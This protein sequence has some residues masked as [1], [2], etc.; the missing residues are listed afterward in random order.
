[1]IH[2]DHMVRA[3]DDIIVPTSLS[4]T[5]TTESLTGTNNL[6]LDR[7]ACVA[8]GENQTTVTVVNEVPNGGISNA[9]CGS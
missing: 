5:S 2:S 7:G 9:M 4:Q 8:N 1:M 6:N 3:Y